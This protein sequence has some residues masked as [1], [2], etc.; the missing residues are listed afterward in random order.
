MDGKLYHKGKRVETVDGK[1]GLQRFITFLG[2][3]SDPVLVAHNCKKFDARIMAYQLMKHCMVNEFQNVCYKF[4]DTLPFMFHRRPGRRGPR[5]YS[6]ENMARDLL[7]ITYDAHNAVEDCETLAKVVE[8]VGHQELLIT[9]FSFTLD[10]IVH[11]QRSKFYHPI[12]FHFPPYFIY[13]TSTTI[14]PMF[15]P[16]QPIFHHL[17]QPHHH[18]TPYSPWMMFMGWN[19]V[20]GYNYNIPEMLFSFLIYAINLIVYI[21][22]ILSGVGQRDTDV[23]LAS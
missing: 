14:S 4:S 15:T 21:D 10:S 18:F 12:S 5:S 7:G 19:G 13:T 3:I 11:V 6:L 8:K 20:K 2:T 17:H 1:T 23:K 16:F 9:Q 22:F